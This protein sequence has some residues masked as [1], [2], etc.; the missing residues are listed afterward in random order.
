MYWTLS[1]TGTKRGVLKFLNEHQ[2]P[3]D[4][5]QYTG[6][7]AL[8]IAEVEALP[9]GAG[10]NIEATGNVLDNGGR[11]FTIRVVPTVILCDPLLT[12]KVQ[13]IK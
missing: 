3:N 7:K 12:R 8:L 1:A 11:P 9:E 4:S 2:G 5:Q 10:V 13:S 6:A